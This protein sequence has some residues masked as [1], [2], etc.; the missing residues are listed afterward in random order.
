MQKD[1]S[2]WLPYR[3][4]SVVTKIKGR[5]LL[6]EML[7]GKKILNNWKNPRAVFSPFTRNENFLLFSSSL[8]ETFT[9]VDFTYNFIHN[10][11]IWQIPT[12]KIKKLWNY[13]EKFVKVT[14]THTNTHWKMLLEKIG[15][16]AS[17][18]IQPEGSTVGNRLDDWLLQRSRYMNRWSLQSGYIP[19][20]VLWDK[21]TFSLLW[22]HSTGH[23]ITREPGG[24]PA[25]VFF[26]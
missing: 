25:Y 12:L 23:N 14:L 6:S 21:T 13:L 16:D 7:R 26:F 3:I 2:V 9:G 24:R 15:K 10:N 1:T 8:F 19:T 20:S 18:R 4:V 5:K 17:R 11:N 22:R